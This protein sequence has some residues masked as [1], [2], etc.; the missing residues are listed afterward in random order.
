[1]ICSST[2]KIVIKLP[3]VLHFQHIDEETGER[4]ELIQHITDPY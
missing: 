4:S 2:S 3:I 1:M